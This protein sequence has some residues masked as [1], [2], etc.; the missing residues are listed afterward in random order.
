MG[1]DRASGMPIRVPGGP[2]ITVR[3]RDGRGRFGQTGAM[4]SLHAGPP[5]IGPGRPDHR[6]AD[7]RRNHERIMKAAL[8]VF[9]EHGLQATV[10]Q[11]AERAGV[12]KATVYRSY[13]AKDDLVNAVA[14]EQ[15]KKLEAR[16]ESALAEPDPYRALSGYVIALFGYLAED[17]VL[18]DALAESTV[19]CA[20]RI[21]DLVA[22]LLEAAK[23]SGMVRQDA[24]SMDIRVVLCGTSLQLMALGERD[25]AVWRRYGQLVLNSLRP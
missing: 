25:P 13:P 6:R 24:T 1:R 7:A 15:F 20:V 10:P 14:G 21:M 16:T 4:D 23:T 19:V 17:R 3:V 18:A 9:A 12:G 22:G 5:V 8:E 11:V 2:G